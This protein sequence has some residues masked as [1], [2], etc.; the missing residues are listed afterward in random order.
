MPSR[1]A[2]WHVY[3]NHHV[4]NSACHHDDDDNHN[5]DDDN[6]GDNNHDEDDDA[7]QVWKTGGSMRQGCFLFLGLFSSSVRHSYMALRVPTWILC[8]REL[9]HL[10]GSFRSRIITG[11]R[12]ECWGVSLRLLRRTQCVSLHRRWQVRL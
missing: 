1:S 5:D 9:L 10:V 2:Q 11:L 3:T 7:V 12:R 4:P 6:H 8:S